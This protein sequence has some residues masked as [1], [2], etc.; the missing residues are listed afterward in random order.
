MANPQYDDLFLFIEGRWIPAAA[1]ET[2]S[3]VNPA[4]E[5]VIGRLPI[6]TAEDLA[7]ALEAA[8][9]GFRVWR[10]VSAHDRSMILRRGAGLIRERANAIALQMTLE[11]GKPV[12]EARRELNAAADIFDW[13]AEEGR[14][15]YG[16]I[17]PAR[18]PGAR[19]MVV[20]EPVGPA[21]AFAPWNFP[22]TTPA[23]KMAASLAAGCSCILK[24]A[25][26]TPATA[27][28][29]A[30]ALD[31]AGL[32]KGV[33]QVVFGEPA[34]V[35]ST[36]LASS[37]I[38]KMSFTGSTAVGKQLTKLAADNMI[39]TTMELGGHAP[40]V[41]FEDA[42]L[43][44]LIPGAV[45]AKFRNAG[46][47]CTSPTRFFVHHRLHDQFVEKFSA[48]ANDLRL[49]SGLADETQ[50]GPL[51]NARRLTAMEGIV[52]GAVE[53]GAILVAGGKRFGNIGYF[54]NPTVLANVPEGAR[55]MHEEPFGPIALTHSF[56]DFDEVIAKANAVP[57]GL[58]AYAF[59]ESFKTATAVSERLESGMV[60]INSFNITVPET[61]FGGVKE[62]GHGSEGGSEGLQAYLAT[63]F[64]S[65][66]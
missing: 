51:A 22:A 52:R 36:L 5:A 1:R 33:L 66:I 39:R 15:A 27:L 21:V 8:E 43:D 31:D 26:E 13:F 20:Q 47:V 64:I 2:L 58:A 9:L 61:P 17:I 57:F 7:R 40:V 60:G 18:E 4:T 12:A 50:M 16:R 23:R 38:R 44:R 56:Q 62:S 42:D 54:W 14:R 45:A 63:K 65:Q 28:A 59:T 10:K 35:S 32:P 3:V 53:D 25:E 19:Y 49:G 29:I 34:R 48:A 11:E 46:Q 55:V 24:P 37:V 41:I 30:R 6:A